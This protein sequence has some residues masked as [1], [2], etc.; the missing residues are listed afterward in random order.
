[1]IQYPKHSIQRLKEDGNYF[2]KNAWFIGTREGGILLV[3]A[4]QRGGAPTEL[5]A[6]KPSV[7]IRK[8]LLKKE[9]SSTQAKQF[10]RSPT[11]IKKPPVR[12]L[13]KCLPGKGLEPLSP[14]GQQFLRLSCIPIPAPRR[15]IVYSY[16]S[17]STAKTKAFLFALGAKRQLI[18]KPPG[19]FPRGRWFAPQTKT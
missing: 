18:Q 3:H 8:I 6:T 10:M 1:M 5:A 19:N 16:Y 15:E 14:C 9:T 7:L 4:R 13:F 11:K 2:Q 12:R 17:K